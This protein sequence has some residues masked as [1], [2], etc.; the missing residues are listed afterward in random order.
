V[1]TE[2]KVSV[3]DEICPAG[4]GDPAARRHDYADSEVGDFTEITCSRRNAGMGSRE[5]T[6]QYQHSSGD[7][8]N[9][10][11]PCMPTCRILAAADEQIE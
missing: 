8:V 6:E 5:E 4:V 7:D 9:F 3:T 11:D 10:A 2:H 1:L